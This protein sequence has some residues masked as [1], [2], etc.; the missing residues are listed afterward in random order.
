[1]Y[2]KLYNQ[3]LDS[4]I[5]SNRK[6]RHFFTDLLLCSDADGNVIKTKAAISRLT[7]A[8]ME[9]VEWGLEELQKPD[10]ESNHR[11]YDG[12]RII[13]LDGHGYGWIIVNYK[14]YRDLKSSSELRKNTA[15]RV[16]RFRERKSKKP[17]TPLNGEVKSVQDF[18]DGVITEEQLAERAANSRE[19]NVR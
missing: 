2:I 9:E 17:G 13:P 3:I 19:H 15:E 4:S 14:F 12:R 16:R 18:E 8:S 11:E 1:M 10:P 5:S 7:G 6:L